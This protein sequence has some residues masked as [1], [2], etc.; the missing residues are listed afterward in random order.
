M[1]S[2][3]EADIEL[4]ASIKSIRGFRKVAGGDPSFDEGK[5]SDAIGKNILRE[6][7]GQ[8]GPYEGTRYT[9]DDATRDILL[10]NARRDIAAT[11][12]VAQSAHAEAHQAKLIS[13]RTALYALAILVLQAVI[14]VMLLNR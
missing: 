14:I 5:I 11:N 9:L 12:S 3:K 10:A 13:R 2:R 7:I 4:D 1:S 8:F 6:E